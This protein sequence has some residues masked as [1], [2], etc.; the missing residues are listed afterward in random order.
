MNAPIPQSAPPFWGVVAA[1][2][3]V[4]VIWGSTYLAIRFAVE[5][6][7]PFLMA[8]TRFLAAGILLY[9]FAR[10]AGAA[11]PIR[12]HWRDAA[13]AG[14]LMLMIG[15]GGV[16]WAEQVIPSGVAALIVA[17]TPVWML[18]FEWLRPNGV[19]PRLD[20]LAGLA[21]G[22]GGVAMLARGE[23]N[24]A[25]PAQ[26]WGIAA[27]LAA[28]IGWAAGSI[29][30]R[31][32]QKPDSA[33]LGV[34]MQ[35]MTGGGLLL[36]ISLALGESGEL[37]FSNVSSA[38]AMAW[39]YLVGAGSL[40]GFTAYIWLLKVSTPARVATYAYVN[41]LIA[42]LLGCT[43]GREPLSRDLLLGAALVIGAVA[44]IVRS[45][46]GPSASIPNPGSTMIP[47]PGYSRDGE[48]VKE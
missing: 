29:F 43:I 32:A 22:F 38:S 20:V 27:L 36:L 15:N 3:A 19:R 34:G 16:T 48:C 25:G 23:Y 21:L 35:M 1:F 33:L 18:L 12:W 28:S 24:G 4:Y 41:P 2:A 47:A 42:V 39:L 40:I 17:I 11:A 46:P 9:A 26:V 10:L 7:P 31:A 5:T 13:I 45:G 37:S 30:N 8:G 14:S 6:I 44:L